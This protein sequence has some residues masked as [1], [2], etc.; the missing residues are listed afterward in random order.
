MVESERYL[1]MLVSKLEIIIE[2]CKAL[3]IYNLYLD[4]KFYGQR[5]NKLY[6]ES[7]KEE[8][9]LKELKSILS[10]YAKE[11]NDKERFGDFFIR[12]GYVKTTKYGKDFHN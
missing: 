7:L 1:P 12:M 8:D 11:R 3:R 9:I 4:E 2:E 6:K 5:L 10:R